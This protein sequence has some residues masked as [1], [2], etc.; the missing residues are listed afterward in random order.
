MV[1][2]K[3]KMSIENG[4]SGQIINDKFRIEVEIVF[5]VK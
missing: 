5:S 2:K 1:Q 3:R 4:I